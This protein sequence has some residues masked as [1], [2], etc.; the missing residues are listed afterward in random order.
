[1]GT[2]ICHNEA[3]RVVL[4]R[5][6][7][8]RTHRPPPSLSRTIRKVKLPGR[9]GRT[10]AVVGTITN[11]V[12]VPEVPKRKAAAL[13]VS[14]RARSRVLKA[15]GKVFTFNQLALDSP[16]G[17]GTVLPSSPRKGRDVC[18]HSGKAPGTPQSHTKPSVRSKGRKFGRAR[19]RRANRGHKH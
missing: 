1:M 5:W 17:C 8:S 6:F 13:R 18:R 19:G 9:G 15:G 2:D 14:S 4:K 7:T 11:D 16:K 3:E 12:R 10:A